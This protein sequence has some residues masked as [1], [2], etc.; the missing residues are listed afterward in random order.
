MVFDGS[1]KGQSVDH[2]RHLAVA[3]RHTRWS[4]LA[5]ISPFCTEGSICLDG[6]CCPPLQNLDKQ[7]M[8]RPGG[9][10]RGVRRSRV[11]RSMRVAHV[12]V[13][14]GENGDG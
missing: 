10:G 12:C 3:A 7:V 8:V 6:S 1:P 5:S 14:R 13:E 11:T 4:A 9:R 2:R